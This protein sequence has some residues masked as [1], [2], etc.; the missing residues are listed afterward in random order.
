LNNTL[1][2]PTSVRRYGMAGTSDFLVGD[3]E[4]A[5]QRRCPTRSWPLTTGL[6]QWRYLI[7]V[8]FGERKFEIYIICAIDKTSVAAVTVEVPE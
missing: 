5:G 6:F 8:L 1:L 2:L 3:L 7:R 4:V